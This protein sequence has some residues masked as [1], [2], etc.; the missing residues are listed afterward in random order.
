MVSSPVRIQVRSKPQAE[1]VCCEMSEA[2]MKMPD[3]IIEPS[4][5]PM[6]RTNPC[7]P[8]AVDAAIACVVSLIRAA[9]HRPARMISH[10]KNFKVLVRT[11]RRVPRAE[12]IADHGYRVRAG[13]NYLFGPF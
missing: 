10:F 7:S 13:L 1:P 2:T 9:P 12:N 6:A 4:N 11:C 8:G 3:P 5:K